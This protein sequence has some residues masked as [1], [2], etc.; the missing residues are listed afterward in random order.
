[1][2]FLALAADYDGTLATNGQVNATT[3][4][5]LKRLRESGRKLLLV[6]GR[7]L[8]DLNTVFPQLDLFDCVVVE[9]GALLYIPATKEERILGDPPPAA[10]IQTLQEQNVQPLGVGRVIVSTWEP[11]ETTVLQA[12]RDLGLELQIIFNKGAVMVLPSGINKASGLRA[13]LTQLDLSPHNAV[14]I[15]DAEND[16]A[17]LDLCEC[18]VAVA[19]ALPVVKDNVDWVTQ[20]SRGDGVVELIDRLLTSDLEAIANQRHRIALGRQD[21]DT[22]VSIQPY[23]SSLLLAG[24][25]GG[26]KS[27]LATGVLERL[28]EQGY[29]FCIIDPEGDYESF[30]GAVVM[31]DGNQPPNLSEV[32]DLLGKPDQNVI[33]N[34]LAVK[35]EERPAF[36][37]GLL[38]LLLELRA[39]TGRPHWIVVDEAHHMLPASWHP[40]SLT[41]PQTFNGMMLITV[42]PDQVATPAL[43]LVNTIVAIGKAPDQTISSFCQSVGYCPPDPIP[44]ED[45]PPG[46]AIVWFCQDDRQPIRFKVLP[47]KGERQRHKRNYAEGLLGDDKCFYFRGAEQKLNL[48]AQNLMMFVQLADGIDQDTWLHHLHQQDYSRWLQVAIKD[49]ELAVEVTEIEQQTDLSA[50]ESRDRVKAAIMQRY[51]LPA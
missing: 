46:D 31:G 49:D 48:K 28:A 13:A 30:E 21:D 51:T 23:G 16:H 2:R 19:N 50:E 32:M 15:G 29:Q 12:I 18:S 45:L 34:L 27:T 20:G 14:A 35:L 9:N 41:L 37:A 26:G 43:S 40:A 36:F 24:T 8:D 47:P 6:S 10:F 42:H 17:M 33:L 39:S 25:S 5:A 38:P 22:E 11:H 3:L 44:A 4:A 1:M 7:H